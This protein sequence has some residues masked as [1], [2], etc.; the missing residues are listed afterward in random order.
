[1]SHENCPRFPSR[2]DCRLRYNVADIESEPGEEVHQTERGI[3][4]IGEDEH[5]RLMEL[6][7]PVIEKHNRIRDFGPG[8]GPDYYYHVAEQFRGDRTTEVAAYGAAEYMVE[9]V[10]DL[11]E[12]LTG[13]FRLWRIIAEAP[14]FDDAIYIYP[15]C[16]RNSDAAPGEPLEEILRRVNA[17]KLSWY[18]LVHRHE[19]VDRPGLQLASPPR[20]CEAKI[21][22]NCSPDVVHAD[23]PVLTTGEI[24]DEL[25]VDEYL[26]FEKDLVPAIERHGPVWVK[27]DLSDT[28]KERRNLFWLVRATDIQWDRTRILVRY[29]SRQFTDE[30]IQDI[31][32][33]LRRWPLWRVALDAEDEREVRFV[34]PDMVR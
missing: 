6:I 31:Q 2:V 22:Y 12:L 14:M 13:P 21:I 28:S 30:L 9:F 15:S 7:A 27:S 26:D 18:R 19:C 29:G 17:H 33:V 16:W 1:M 10:L 5:Y 24:P 3:P 20:L 23:W 34:Y 4:A 8:S 25:T 32:S 11:Q